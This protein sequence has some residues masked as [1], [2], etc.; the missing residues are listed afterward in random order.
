MERHQKICERAEVF[1]NPE[2]FNEAFK[3]GALNKN[4]VVVIRSQGPQSNGMPELHS[5]NPILSVIQNLGYKIALITDGRMSGAS[6]S[7]LT[8]VH[9]TPE[10]KQGGIISKIQNSDII[11]IDAQKGTMNVNAA[12][13]TITFDGVM[14]GTKELKAMNATSA[15]IF[16]AAA[17]IEAVA[18]TAATT[19]EAALKADTISVTDS[20]L[21]LNAAT[22]DT[23]QGSETLVLTLNDTSGTGQ[24]TFAPGA[25]VSHTGTIV[26]AAAGEGKVLVAVGSGAVGDKQT[27]TTTIGADGTAVG[28]VSVGTSTLA[29]NADFEGAIN[30]KNAEVL[31]AMD[32][33]L[34][35]KDIL[36]F[37]LWKKSNKF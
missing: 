12:S 13:G 19:Y 23:D 31:D 6:G 16:K 25:G 4:C 9:V 20:V 18:I 1:Q 5:L 26:A 37:S 32:K 2:E 35:H 10:T 33:I 36:E 7:V 27:F 21:T 17:D 34:N 11:E 28:D 3:K 15:A 24:V 8:V 22:I 14:G 30:A 29:G